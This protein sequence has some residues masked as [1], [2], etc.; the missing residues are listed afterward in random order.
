MSDVN[1]APP[2][3]AAA[4]A[5]PAPAANE[6]VINQNPVSSPQPVGSQA[7][8]K[9]VD[10]LQGSKHRPESRRESIQKAFERSKEPEAEER[11]KTAAKRGMGDN[12]PP[13]PMEKEKIDLKKRP[14]QHREGG[15]F[16]RAPD[17]EPDGKQQAP[18]QQQQARKTAN[19][20]TL[21]D[22][23][24]YRDPPPRMGE[25]AKQEWAAAPESV[26]GEVHRMHQEFGEAFKRYRADTETMNTIRP[27]HQM[28]TQHGTTLERALTNYVSMEQKLRSDVIGGLD[29][30]VNNLNL[31]TPDGRKLGLRDVAYHILNQSPDQHR[32]VQNSNAQTAMSAQIGQLHQIVSSLAQN[33]QQMHH[34]EQFVQTRSAVDKYADTHPR[35]DELGD[36][37]E[38]ELRYG[39]DLDTAYRRAEL[40]RPATHAAQTRNPPAQ[41]RSDKSIHGAPDGSSLSDRQPRRSSDKPIGR[42]EAIANAI[43]RVNGGV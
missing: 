19:V 26:R 42:R 17:K 34:R 40:L 9:P 39:F 22:G 15:K 3:P 7:P 27:F 28:A 33:Q 1:V 43:K 41:T 31:R 32:I 2:A 13:E 5:A 23:A 29:V 4:P 10:D 12:N 37:I 11:R 8:D 18:G 20:V 24:P 21:P 16:A 6:V 36:L 30:I 38:Q 25:H 35:F 14:E